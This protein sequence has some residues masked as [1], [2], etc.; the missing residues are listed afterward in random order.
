MY[1]MKWKHSQQT[2]TNIFTKQFEEHEQVNGYEQLVEHE[3]HE[4]HEGG[5]LEECNAKTN[6]TNTRQQQ[7]LKRESIRPAT[8]TAIVSASANKQSIN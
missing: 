1:D 8:A 5:D 7:K 4:K 6:Q 2:A 3:D